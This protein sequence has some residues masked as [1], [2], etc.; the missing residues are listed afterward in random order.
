MTTALASL[1]TGRPVKHTVGMTGEVTLQGRVLPIGGLKQKVLAAHAAGLTEVFLPERNRGDLDDVP[2]EVREQM[3]FHP[4]MSIDEVLD[5]GARAGRSR[6]PMSPRCR[7]CDPVPTRAPR[8]RGPAG[9]PLDAG[10]DLRLLQRRR[11]L[12]RVPPV[13]AGGLADH[14]LG[15][16][17]AARG[18]RDRRAPARP[19]P[20]AARR[21]PADREGQAAGD[22]GGRAAR[23]LVSPAGSTVAATHNVRPVSRAI[24]PPPPHPGAISPARARLRRGARG[25]PAVR[26]ARP[27]ELPLRRGGDGG[28]GPAPEPL[29]HA[30]RSPAQRVDST[31]YYGLAWLW[32]RLFGTGEVGIRSL[33]ALAGTAT[34]VVVYLAGRELLSRRAGLIAAAIVAVSP[35]MI[36]FSQDARAYALVFLL[37]SLSS[38]SSPARS[39][40]RRR[41]PSP[42][43]RSPP[44]WP[45]PPTTS[46]LRG[47][48][49]GD[50]APGPEPERRA[51]LSIG[52]IVAAAGL[53]APIAVQQ[54]GHGHASW[55]AHQAL[56]ERF[57]RAVAKLVGDDNGGVQGPRPSDT[58]PLLVPVALALG[59]LALL[60]VRGDPAERR[61]SGGNRRRSRARRS[62]RGPPARAVGQRLLRGQEPDARLRAADGRDRRRLR[63]PASRLAGPALAAV[64]CLCGLIYTLEIDR[65]PRLQREDLR[66]A[67]EQIGPAR[68]ARDHHR[69]ARRQ[70]A[71]ALLPRRGARPFAAA[72][73]AG[74]R[75]PRLALGD[76]LPSPAAP[77][78]VPPGRGEGRFLQ[79]HAGAP[80]RRGPTP[81]PL[82]L[83]RRGALVGGGP[84]RRSWWTNAVPLSS[85]VNA[86]LLARPPAGGEGRSRREY[87]PGSQRPRSPRPEGTR[88]GSAPEWR[89]GLEAGRR[90]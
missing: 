55:I 32:T 56:S 35:A 71:A 90:R 5:A 88:R 81:V 12:Q 78:R 22:G 21:V 68:G 66:N 61:G 76:R 49:G 70:L 73:P 64:F 14:A 47:R 75:P 24:G 89:S 45:S 40:T 29:R 25:D 19:R 54:A 1:L 84:A 48:A 74:D 37:V 52:A 69:P 77:G 41:A 67:A 26:D 65:L 80:A 42:P 15:A 6:E 72:G 7:S 85:G 23:R 28:P 87:R 16:P 51:P 59:A 50:P 86:Q 39:A 13:A 53:L 38:S 17:R 63:R 10:H 2:E 60:L 83:L 27:A 11:A 31:L 46:R 8:R 62:R 44:R 20:P 9:A 58:V 33:S 43:G 4:V 79:L 3:T 36:W 82:S 30:L 34:I 18:G 57:D